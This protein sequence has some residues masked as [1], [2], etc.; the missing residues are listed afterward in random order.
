MLL[1]EAVRWI[2]W[3]LCAEKFSRL[4]VAA[5]GKRDSLRQA[6]QPAGR[7]SCLRANRRYGDGDWS[8]LLRGGF[9]HE[10]VAFLLVAGEGALDDGEGGVGGTDVFDIDALAF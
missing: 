8:E 7:P 5:L 1:Q 6:K 3:Q 9:A 10:A 2:E 4:L